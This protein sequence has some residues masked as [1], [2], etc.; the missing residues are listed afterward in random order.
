MTNI[1]IFK[2]VDK[3]SGQLIKWSDIVCYMFM[4]NGLCLCIHNTVLLLSNKDYQAVQLC[5][6][7]SNAFYNYNFYRMVAWMKVDNIEQ[8]LMIIPTYTK[9][10]VS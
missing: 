1:T 3:M 4:Q 2:C 9:D 6:I 10:D 7:S 5:T 8:E